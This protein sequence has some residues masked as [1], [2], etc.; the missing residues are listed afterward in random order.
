MPTLSAPYLVVLYVVCI[1]QAGHILFMS[2][3]A[4]QSLHFSLSHASLHYYFCFT[5]MSQ[6]K[7]TRTR[8]TIVEASCMLQQQNPKLSLNLKLKLFIKIDRLHNTAANPG[9]QYISLAAQINVVK[10]TTTFE[11]FKAGRGIIT[12]LPTPTTVKL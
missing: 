2:S 9:N 12:K 5:V 7:W 11:I 3:S 4:K 10:R 6:V 1:H 8:F